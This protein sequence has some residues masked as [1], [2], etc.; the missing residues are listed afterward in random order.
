[1]RANVSCVETAHVGV[2]RGG[3]VDRIFVSQLARAL[4]RVFLRA[5]VRWFAERA[6]MLSVSY[7]DFWFNE[8]FEMSA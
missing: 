5:K 6:Y 8:D 3:F 1:M 2:G 7:H 4:S